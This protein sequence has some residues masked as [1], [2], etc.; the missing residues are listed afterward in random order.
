MAIV[1]SLDNSMKNRLDI[2]FVESDFQSMYIELV[3]NLSG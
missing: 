2:I 3:S 1:L